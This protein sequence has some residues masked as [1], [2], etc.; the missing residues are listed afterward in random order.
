MHCHRLNAYEFAAGMMRLRR[1]G[2][3]P[4]LQPP[5]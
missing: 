2:A 3:G 4:A 1:V 5:G